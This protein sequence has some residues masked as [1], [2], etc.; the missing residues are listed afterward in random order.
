MSAYNILKILNNRH[1][2]SDLFLKLI[3]DDKSVEYLKTF[4]IIYSL[5]IFSKLI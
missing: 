2:T 1:R 5:Q 4:G 3:A